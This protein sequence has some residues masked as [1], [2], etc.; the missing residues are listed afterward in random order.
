MYATVAR[1]NNYNSV[2]CESEYA[3]IDQSSM[4]ET[5]KHTYVSKTMQPVLVES[6]PAAKLQ[7]DKVLCILEVTSILFGL[8]FLGMFSIHCLARVNTWL[9]L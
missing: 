7:K 3:E 4:K 2:S 1:N 9:Q 5:S 8:I 6:R